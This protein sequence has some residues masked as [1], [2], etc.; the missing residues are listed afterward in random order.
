MRGDKNECAR[1]LLAFSQSVSLRKR[2][3]GRV[4]VGRP[5]AR[6]GSGPSRARGGQAAATAGSGTASHKARVLR[7]CCHGYGRRT[8]ADR[9]PRGAAVEL[10]SWSPSRGYRT[11]GRPIKYRFL[12]LQS[13]GRACRTIGYVEKKSE[14][15]SSKTRRDAS[16]EGLVMRWRRTR[17]RRR[18]RRRLRRDKY[19][20]NDDF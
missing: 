12:A 13:H 17:T 14:R 6:A 15:K 1:M 11:A 9:Q 16:F 7:S 3:G 8:P 10:E 19:E 5:A 4:C 2:R 20:Q 18:I